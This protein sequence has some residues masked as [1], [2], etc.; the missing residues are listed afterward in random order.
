MDPW[1]TWPSSQDTDSPAPPLVIV[2]ET[3]TEDG[4][5]GPLEIQK[6]LYFI[7]MHFKTPIRTVQNDLNESK[8]VVPIVVASINFLL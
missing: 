7:E 3:F 4:A 5:G 2:M 8:D 6:Q 1:T